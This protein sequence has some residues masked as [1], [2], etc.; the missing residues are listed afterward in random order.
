MKTNIF[1]VREKNEEKEKIVIEEERTKNPF[2]LSLRRH[3]NL[4]LLLLITLLVSMFLISVGV[5]FSLF[6]GSNDYDISYI[7]GDETINSNNSSLTDEEIKE[8]LLG[9]IARAEGIVVLVETFMSEQ[10]DVIS[11]YTDG[12]AV[13]VQSNG[14]I[15]RISTN[16]KG[17]YGINRNGKIDST[18]K[19]ILVTSTTNTLPD[20]TIITYYSDGTAKV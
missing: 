20:G 8:G 19:K 16:N 4:I 12:T 5:V 9:E 13:V 3:K 6:Q 17:T 18:A 10:G 14:N 15:Y 1:N 11:Y 2:L 7:E